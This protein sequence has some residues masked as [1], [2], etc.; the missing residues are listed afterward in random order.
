MGILDRAKQQAT[1]LRGRAEEKVQ[2]IADKRHADQLLEQLGRLTY[3]E[4]TERGQTDDGSASERI[5]AE[6]RTLEGK[7]TPVL[8]GR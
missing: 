4:R 2:D 8:D 6:L 1:E 5:V 3:A 7:G